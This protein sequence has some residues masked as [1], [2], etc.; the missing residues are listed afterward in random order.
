[1]VNLWNCCSSSSFFSSTPSFMGSVEKLVN[2]GQKVYFVVYFQF[3]ILKGDEPSLLDRLLYWWLPENSTSSFRT[4]SLA[5]KIGKLETKTQRLNSVA[6]NSSYAKGGACK[7]SFHLH[8]LLLE[9]PQM[10]NTHPPLCLEHG[11]R[12]QNIIFLY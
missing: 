9:R 2:K 12:Q 7:N 8:F 6:K 3:P 4:S 11:V 1:M 5:L 10:P